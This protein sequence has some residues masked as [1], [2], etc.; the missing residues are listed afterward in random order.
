MI[1]FG[2]EESPTLTDDLKEVFFKLIYAMDYDSKASQTL[3]QI[4]EY[5]GCCG[6][7]G[8]EDYIFALKPVPNE[9]RDMV[10]GQEYRYGCAQQLAW[11]LEPW[12]ATLAGICIVF[13]ILQLVQV[14]LGRRVSSRIVSYQRTAN[15]EY[16]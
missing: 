1:V 6:A 12:S 9:C 11:W 14:M 4:Q 8:S 5:V 7:I 16:E 15:N 13:L 2:V 3:K 10:T